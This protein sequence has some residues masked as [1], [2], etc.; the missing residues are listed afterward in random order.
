[1]SCKTF[2]GGWLAALL[3]CGLVPTAAAQST[4]VVGPPFEDVVG[5][6]ASIHGLR[7]FDFSAEPNTGAACTS[8][9]WTPKA[10]VTL[11]GAYAIAERLIGETKWSNGCGPEGNHDFVVAPLS[12]GQAPQIQIPTGPEFGDSLFLVHD[13]NPPA[14]VLP[15]QLHP[16]ALWVDEQNTPCHPNNLGEGAFSIAFDLDQASFGI[17]VLYVKKKANASALTTVCA[18]A[19]WNTSLSTGGSLK[20]D[21][22]DRAGSRIDTV[23]YTPAQT[24]SCLVFTSS[25]AGIAGVTVNNIDP[26]GIAF[27]RLLLDCACLPPVNF[28][29]ATTTATAGCTP[30]ILATGTASAS[31]ASAFQITGTNLLNRRMGTLFYSVAGPQLPAVP[32]SGGG[33]FLCLGGMTRKLPV[34]G[35]GGT[36]KPVAD[37]S[38]TLSF[39]FGAYIAS[40]ANPAL[41]ACTTV[42]AQL[43]FRDQRSLALS[44][45]VEFTICP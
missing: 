7:A 34:T 32:F 28:C 3:A 21:F 40:G 44:D 38:G 35:T 29:T 9:P 12:L 8:L 4:G 41:E 36:A 31:G 42:W 27:S 5:C 18:G 43:I 15:D 30:A 22:Y 24:H 10:T 2:R 19:N 20:F 16:S 39:D 37:C 26:G 23:Y 6:D 1:M 33:G 13:A 11:P 25:G 45:A 14:G 17:D